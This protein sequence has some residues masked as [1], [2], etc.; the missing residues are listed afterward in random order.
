MKIPCP[1]C[2]TLL[3]VADGVMDHEVRCPGCREYV[4]V[5]DPAVQRIWIQG[6][7]RYARGQLFKDVFWAA[8]ILWSLFSVVGWFVG[9]CMRD[10]VPRIPGL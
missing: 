7:S 8:V 1:E 4:T 10:E 6:L 3:T 9:S 2:Q 5:S